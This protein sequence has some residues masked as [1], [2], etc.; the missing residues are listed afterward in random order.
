[1]WVSAQAPTSA[2][3]S[4]ASGKGILIAAVAGGLTGGW[5]G[6][7]EDK[8]L[9]LLA[10]S[11][12]Q[13]MAGVLQGGKFGHGFASAMAGGLIGNFGPKGP[14]NW[15]RAAR[16]GLGAVAGGT[17]S[18]ITGGK[19][20][21]GAVSGAFAAAVMEGFRLSQ[22][23]P[24]APPPIELPDVEVS[25]PQ[26]GYV[27]SEETPPDN[28]EHIPKHRITPEIKKQMLISRANAKRDLK[29]AVLDEAMQKVNEA[30]VE[31][32]RGAI[33]EVLELFKIDVPKHIL[34][35]YYIGDISEA[36]VGRALY[37]DTHAMQ[38]IRDAY[39]NRVQKIYQE[40]D[41]QIEE[42]NK[43]FDRDYD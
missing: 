35:D 11:T 12:I 22:K 29:L 24:P 20:A 36:T 23:A 7:L 16:I 4:G 8:A 3:I 6:G 25:E 15:A 28:Y 18:K 37:T 32:A 2:A 14:S 13:G 33:A 43:Y 9:A 38:S 27:E 5:A 40:Y 39:I 1:M 42:I 26:F 34:E 10:T 41:A 31:G 19:F 30:A 17:T 21:N